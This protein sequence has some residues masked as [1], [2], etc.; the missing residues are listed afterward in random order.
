MTSSE[1]PLCRTGAWW[2]TVLAGLY[3]GSRCPQLSPASA[4]ITLLSFPERRYGKTGS[5]SKLM[6][7]GAVEKKT[8]PSPQGGG[9]D[10]QKGE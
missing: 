6:I 8:W 9:C 7:N 3:L 1:A 10:S 4:F 2:R 5:S